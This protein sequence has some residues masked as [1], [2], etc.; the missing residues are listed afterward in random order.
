LAIDR[1]H[2]A[3]LTETRETRDVAGQAVAEQALTQLLRERVAVA[4]S[5]KREGE[6][7]IDE[8]YRMK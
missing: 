2:R 8:R 7:E 4:D 3:H 6:R 5:E 1:S